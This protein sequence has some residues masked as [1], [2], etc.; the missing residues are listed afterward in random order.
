MTEARIRDAAFLL[1]LLD[2]PTIGPRRALKVLT[3]AG[4]AERAHEVLLNAPSTSEAV[5]AFLSRTSLDEYQDSLDQTAELGGDFKL[6]SDEDYPENLQQWEGHPPILFFKG[7]LS[8][9]QRRSLA[10]VGRTDPTED[11]IAAAG[12]FARKCVE[13]DIQVV[14]GLAKGI[15]GASHRGAL[16]EPG[17][18]TYAVL[19]HGIDH[20]YPSDNA[21]LYASIP[22]HGALISQFRTGVGPQKWT[23]PARNEVMCTLALGTVIVEA[24]P[25]CG[26]L[27]QADFSLKHN[28]PVFV[29]HR[30]LNTPDSDWAV[31][32]VKR[33]AHV[34]EHFDQVLDIVSRQQDFAQREPT[35]S[36]PISLFDDPRP[37]RGVDAAPSA[38]L[39]D[40]DGVVV[41]TRA[42]TAQALSEIAG[43]HLDQTFDPSSINVARSPHEVLAHLGVM[44]A[45]E[46]YRAE[47]DQEFTRALG[48][49]T[50]FDAVI[51]GIGELKRAGIRVAAV[52]AQPKRRIEAILPENVRSLFDAVFCY[53]DTRGKKEVGIALALSHFGVAKERAVFVGDQTT[54][55]AGARKAG[56]KGVGVLW[57]FCTEAELRQW[58]HD[59]LLAKPDE[60]AACLLGLLC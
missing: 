44:G 3:E 2:A 45:Y 54:D 50:V 1:R 37:E 20:A 16:C 48:K 43:R 6:W 51:E 35:T 27:I 17:G 32:L 28:R 4:D 30:N 18:R 33:G 21:D 31:D 9:L 11:G 13:S 60:L 29:L 38:A 56:I 49:V 59:M 40:L 34:V 19:G 15:D 22:S 58:P 53:N 57:G 12:R 42:A 14:S 8:H 52:T 55:L 46:I 10:L 24:K 47:F 39:F 23:F 5:R 26:S 25:R 41:D 7:D 36:V